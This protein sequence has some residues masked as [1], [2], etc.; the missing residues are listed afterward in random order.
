MTST[1]RYVKWIHNVIWTKHYVK[2]DNKIKLKILN[3]II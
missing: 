3:Q 2:I 1:R